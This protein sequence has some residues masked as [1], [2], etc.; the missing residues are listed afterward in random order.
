VRFRTKLILAAAYLLLVVVIALEIPL[1]VNISERARSEL[2]SSLVAASSVVAARINDDLPDTGLDPLVDPAPPPFIRE[3]VDTTA[4]A[5]GTRIVVTDLLGR[6]VADSADEAQV[7]EEYMTLDRPEFA[8]V[9]DGK[10]DVRTRHSDM[11]NTD[12]LLVTAPVV[13]NRQ[14]IGAVRLSQTLDEVNDRVRRSL[15]GLAAIGAA[16]IL[17]GLGLAWLLSLAIARPVRRLAGTAARLGEGDLEARAEAT[18]K[19][20]LAILGRNFNRM[21]DS[22]AANLRAQRDFLA[23]ASHQLRTPLTG[24]R[25]RLEAIESEGGP[26]AVQAAKAQAEVMRLSQ[27]VEDLLELARAISVEA[28]GGRI[29]LAEAARNAVDRWSG[30]AAERGKRLVEHIDSPCVVVASP[31]DL[32]QLLDNLIENAIR[33]TPEGTEISVETG[34][35]NGRILLTVADSG[36]GIAPEDHPRVFERFYRGSAGKKAGPGTGLGLAL[37]SE[38]A[39]RWGGRVRLADGTGARFEASFPPAPTVP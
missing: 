24:L 4:L 23:N 16:V 15:I 21:A 6:V 1:G 28:T 12:L 38:L 33:Y 25:L 18:G 9:F 35:R 7:G 22:L 17:V 13:H 36:P 34:T 5:T 10:I 14:V 3:V 27:L 19:G 39:E 11:L 30:P 2:E 26:A 32:A 37:V 8:S 29:D 31:D 20:E